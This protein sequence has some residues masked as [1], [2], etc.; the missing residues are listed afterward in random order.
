VHRNAAIFELDRA[1]DYILLQEKFHGD[2]SNG[3]S[4]TVLTNKRPN[5]HTHTHKQTVLKTIPHVVWELA[6]EN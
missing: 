1:L 6:K 2:I 3:S 4:V 5:T